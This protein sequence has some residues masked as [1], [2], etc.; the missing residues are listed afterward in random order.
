[1]DSTRRPAGPV[2]KANH[3]K[4]NHL[5]ANHLKAN[6]LN[7]GILKDHLSLHRR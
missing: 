6:R 4:A 2:P 5:K 1:M 7:N 3:L